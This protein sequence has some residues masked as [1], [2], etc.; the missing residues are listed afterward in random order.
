LR[1][2]VKNR[3]KVMFRWNAGH[4]FFAVVQ[5]FPKGAASP[6]WRTTLLAR[7]SV[8]C[9]ACPT[10]GV[11]IRDAAMMGG[12]DLSDRKTGRGL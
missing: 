9:Y 1:R 10:T 6:L 8:L 7:S 11:K 4:H 5:G 2:A 3:K 12:A